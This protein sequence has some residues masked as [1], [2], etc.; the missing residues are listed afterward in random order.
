MQGISGCEE[1][2]GGREGPCK[3]LGVWAPSMQRGSFHGHE[4]LNLLGR[5]CG[6]RGPGV[7]RDRLA[8]ARASSSIPAAVPTLGGA[9]TAD[10]RAPT[11]VSLWNWQRPL[12]KQWD[13]FL[14]D[15]QSVCHSLYTQLCTAA[16]MSS[17]I[18]S[19]HIFSFFL[20][21]SYDGQEDQWLCP[22]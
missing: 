21:K 11:P 14:Q 9:L 19:I 1:P 8:S 20:N 5:Q 6:D 17:N 18:K 13:Q 3:H 16:L 12:G 15:S 10:L 7:R 22:A 2:E 4:V